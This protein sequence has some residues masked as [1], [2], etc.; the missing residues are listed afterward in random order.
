MISL[1]IDYINIIIGMD[2]KAKKLILFSQFFEKRFQQLPRL[3]A[4]I[5]PTDYPSVT[6]DDRPY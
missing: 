5:P 2:K 4:V 6:N 3:D 1:R